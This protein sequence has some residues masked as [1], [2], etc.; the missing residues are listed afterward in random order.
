MASEAVRRLV[1]RL[2]SAYTRREGSNFYKFFSVV[3]T[4]AEE[5]A[6]AAVRDAHVVNRAFGKSL[7][8]IGQLLNVRRWQGETDEH[9]RTRLKIAG[10]TATCTATVEDVRRV[11]AVALQVPTSRI[12]VK[13]RHDVEPAYFDV[14]VYL[15]DV[16][17]AGLT[18]E[19]LKD[20]LRDVKPAGVALST[21][22][23]GTFTCRSASESSDPAKGYNDLANSNPDGGTYAGLL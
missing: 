6:I 5:S 22:Q 9:L 17:N 3:E 8:N 19:E 16:V 15:Q 18:V 14:W 20:V 7:E 1:R 23:L 21:K 12:R 10:A 4:S 11:V 2:P 13:E